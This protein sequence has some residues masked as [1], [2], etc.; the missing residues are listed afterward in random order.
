[1]ML[2]KHYIVLVDNIS[3]KKIKTDNLS[4]CE[5]AQ[6]SSLRYH[7]FFLTSIYHPITLCTISEL[8]LRF[9]HTETCLA[10]LEQHMS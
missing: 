9:M 4:W 2:S 3:H 10:F 1:M 5:K 6:P 7:S 8:R